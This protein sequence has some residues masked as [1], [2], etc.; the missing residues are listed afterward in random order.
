MEERVKNCQICKRPLGDHVVFN[1]DNLRSQSNTICLPDQEVLARPS[2]VRRLAMAYRARELP[3]RKILNFVAEHLY[4]YDGAIVHEG[5][6]TVINSQVDI[7]DI[8]GTDDDPSER[9]LGSFLAFAVSPPR[10][11]AQNR[12]IIR[13][14][15]LWLALAIHNPVQAELVIQ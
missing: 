3:R 14:S 15:V 11:Y 1:N 13:L 8:F 2:R 12:V 10:Q 9:W 7:D 4:Q 6:D 5:R